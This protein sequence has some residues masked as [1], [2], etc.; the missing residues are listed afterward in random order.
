[1]KRKLKIQGN[2]LEDDLQKQVETTTKTLPTFDV[3][4]KLETELTRVQA[5]KTK[6]IEALNKIRMLYDPYVN[7][8]GT[9]AAAADPLQE[10]AEAVVVYIPGEWEEKRVIIRP[11]P[12]PQETFLSS[13]AD[14]VIYGGAAGGGKSYALLLE[15]L[16][17]IKTIQI[18]AQ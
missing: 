11:Q 13:P 4:Y 8:L 16:R 18:S 17:H 3:I 7:S 2:V 14:I 5:K 1:M 10:D 12:G 6:C 9:P 15:P